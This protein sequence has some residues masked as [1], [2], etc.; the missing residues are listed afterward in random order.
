MQP[1][2]FAGFGEPVLVSHRE[3]DGQKPDSE[4]VLQRDKN[5]AKL[6]VTKALNPW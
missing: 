2:S 1:H 4:A 3:L 5:L 6:A